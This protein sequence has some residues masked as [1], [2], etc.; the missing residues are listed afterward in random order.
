[1]QARSA[2]CDVKTPLAVLPR[3]VLSKKHQRRRLAAVRAVARAAARAAGMRAVAASSEHVRKHGSWIAVAGSDS[4]MTTARLGKRYM[5]VIAR[6]AARAGCLALCATLQTAGAERRGR[7]VCR[8][9][10]GR[11]QDLRAAPGNPEKYSCQIRIRLGC[12]SR[13]VG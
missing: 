11:S 3:G 7:D 6:G 10:H 9:R 1:M 2:P 12:A 5:Q 8:P 13:F 4:D